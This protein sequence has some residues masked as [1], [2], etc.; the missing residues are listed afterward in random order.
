VAGTGFASPNPWGANTAYLMATNAR[1]QRTWRIENYLQQA[2]MAQ[3]STMYLLDGSQ[4]ALLVD[5]AQN[6]PEVMGQNDLKTL[7]RHLLGHNNDGSVRSSPVDFVAAISHSHGDHTGKNSQMSDR[8]IYFPDLDW[9]ASAPANY[10]PMK[11]GGGATTHGS[12]TAAG[13]IVL[14]GRTIKAINIY[15]HTPGSLGFLDTENNMILTSDAIGSGLVWAHFGPITR[16]AD[17]LRHLKAVLQPMDNPAILPG[18][19]YQISA[20]ARGKPPINGRPLD[21]QYVD[22]QLAVAEGVLKG[23]IAGKPYSAGGPSVLVAQFGSAEMT[24]TEAG[25]GTAPAPPR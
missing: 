10:V 24:Y 21:K 6:T 25:L 12:G 17:S 7:V 3:G 18:H 19:F 1:G 5:T 23:T 16:Y 13:E 14:G 20:G 2:S 4:R 9:P 22:D 11:E 8:T 15:G